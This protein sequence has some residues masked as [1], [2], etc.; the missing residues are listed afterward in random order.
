M[1]RSEF[2]KLLKHRL[3]ELR[4]PANQQEGLLHF[5]V[6]ELRKCAQRAIFDGNRAS[7]EICF[8]LAEEAYV[9]GDKNLKDAIDV[10]FVEGLDFATD[11]NSYS[12]AWEMMPDV[13]KKLYE[14]FRGSR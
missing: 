2:L 1:H 4:Q 6:D 12:W 11:H 7:L 13:L 10:S 14:E 5:E 8:R 9:S 3:P